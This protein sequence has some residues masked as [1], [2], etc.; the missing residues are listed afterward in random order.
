[1]DADHDNEKDTRTENLKERQQQKQRQAFKDRNEI[2]TVGRLKTDND[3]KSNKLDAGSVLNKKEVN[4]IIFRHNDINGVDK[5][6]SNVI[7]SEIVVDDNFVTVGG[8]GS[9]VVSVNFPLVLTHN[10][11]DNL[12]V[13][14]KEALNG[15][16]LDESNN[17]EVGSHSSDGSWIPSSSNLNESASDSAEVNSSI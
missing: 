2:T 5:V 3:I 15:N 1:M 9:N 16:Q 7:D 13:A 4:L 6:T 12:M 14:W 8:I 17:Q 10:E 11:E